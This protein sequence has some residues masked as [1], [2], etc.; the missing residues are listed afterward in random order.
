MGKA[1][2][3]LTDE[4]IQ[5][6]FSDVNLTDRQFESI[7]THFR[8]SGISVVDDASGESCGRL[9]VVRSPTSFRSRLT[10]ES[11]GRGHRHPASA[12]GRTCQDRQEEA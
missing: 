1:K 9:A 10:R 7:Y 4:E 12:Q 3:N 6:A 8:E 5:A 2:G 11:R